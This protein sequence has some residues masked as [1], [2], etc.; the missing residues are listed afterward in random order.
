MKMELP[1]AIRPLKPLPSRILAWHLLLLYLE[2]CPIVGEVGKGISANLATLSK[3]YLAKMPRPPE[4]VS[5]FT[6][7]PSYLW[8]W[9]PVMYLR[10]GYLWPRWIHLKFSHTVFMSPQR[11]DVRLVSMENLAPARLCSILCKFFFA[12]IWF[13]F[14]FQTSTASDLSAGAAL[15]EALVNI[16]PSFFTPSW[17]AGILYSIHTMLVRNWWIIYRS[18][19]ASFSQK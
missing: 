14:S 4:D 6:E 13:I 2:Y 17:F 3:Q 15:S 19:S 5:A 12:Q 1:Q 11:S 10:D 16:E 8:R 9:D 18:K 7:R